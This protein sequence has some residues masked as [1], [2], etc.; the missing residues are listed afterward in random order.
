MIDAAGMARLLWNNWLPLGT[1]R[2]VAGGMTYAG[3]PGVNLETAEKLFIFLAAAHDLGKAI[4]AFQM[5]NFAMNPEL[6]SQLA[7]RV[8][9]TGL[10]M[11]FRPTSPGKV[12]HSL[13]SQVILE[14]N[15]CNRSFAIVVGGHHG[16]PPSVETADSD[17][18]EAWSGNT[19]FADAGWQAVQKEVLGFAAR[20]AGID[21]DAAKSVT[22]TVPAQVILTGQVIMADWIVSD[23]KLFPYFKPHEDFKVS[24]TRANDAWDDLLLTQPWETAAGWMGAELFATRFPGR[25]PLRPV[26]LKVIE[27][28]PAIENP[29]IVIIEAPMGEGK[30]E[31]ALAA[32]EILAAKMNR[33]GVFFALPTQATS[34]GIFPRL[35]NWIG[36]L[37]A[38]D[39]PH[40]LFLAHG[41]SRFNEEYRRL[42]K[43]DAF[44]GGMNGEEDD[45]IVAHDWFEGR[46]KGMLA[47]FVVG[48][49]DQLLLAGLKQKHFMLRHLGL[50]NKVVIIDECHAYDAY[51]SQYLFKVLRW[52]G[53]YN[54]PVVVLSATLPPG[55]RKKL[56]DAYLRIPEE[57]PSPPPW[58]GQAVCEPLAAESAATL[59]YPLVTYSDGKTIQRT[60][61]PSSDRRLKA[62]IQFLPDE[63]IPER[64]EHLLTDGGCAGIIV[65]TVGRA[66]NFAKKLAKNF[67]DGTVR[68]FHSRFIS[69]ARAMKELELR[70]ILG[71]ESALRPENLVVVG[72]QVME[73]SLDVD[74]D[75]LFTDICP[76]DLLLQRMG[77][78]H[79]HP[80][81]RPTALRQAMCFI[82]G[83]IGDDFDKGS[84]LI[85]G[86]YL[87]INSKELLRRRDAV[88][89]PDDIAALVNAAYAPDGVS[90]EADLQATYCKAKEKERQRI[91]ER[92]RKAKTFQ[93]RDPADGLGDL[94][95]C[96]DIS[97]N[98]DKTGKRAEATVRD[99]ND[100]VEV[101][102]IQKRENG[103]LYFLPGVAVFGKQEIPREGID[104]ECASA[105]AGCTVALPPQLTVPRAIKETITR[106]EKENL[107]DIPG[108]WQHSCWL[109]DELFLVL[110][111]GLSAD[112]GEY[113]LRYD[114]TLGLLVEYRGD[115]DDC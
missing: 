104:D 7:C 13:A 75:V 90:V 39:G 87:L 18:I 3:K 41:K 14:R 1:K 12:H 61:V 97:V 35:K 67:G 36:N 108:D 9:K 114:E 16:K 68:L 111:D 96:L 115:G 101:I 94:T 17:T 79:R 99:A 8:S 11:D 42:A 34:D 10:R 89:F 40:S 31:A 103:R 73:Q 102:V 109:K 21:A 47:D 52:L 106:L 71:P 74:F 51:M 70:G 2:I 62:A 45:S 84:K 83:M 46:K 23:E 37:K 88:T 44:V 5:G 66:Q 110:D 77:R 69:S 20:L 81:P 78:L 25:T 49:I 53:A 56:L 85:Y 86:E 50:A 33:A 63:K 59:E 82:T 76:M 65:N 58:A 26:Q 107:R 112:F 30:T 15:G 32:A 105:V 28:V 29:G 100:S 93:I 38:P 80:R 4:P 92:E 27:T 48:T 113:T 64:L 54:T 22:L 91:E 19:G 43:V 6:R 95:S 72:T 55:R 98:D 60:A 57:R 24:G